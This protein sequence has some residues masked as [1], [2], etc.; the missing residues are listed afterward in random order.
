MCPRRHRAALFRCE[1]GGDTMA[2]D[3]SLRAERAW[4]KIQRKAVSVVFTKPGINLKTGSS[5]AVELAAQTVKISSDSR[6]SVIGGNAGVAPKRAVIV[7]GIV[8]HPTEPDSD[9]K[10]GYTFPYAGESY[11]VVDIIPG[12]PGE[13]QAQAT[14]LG[15]AAV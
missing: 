15:S 1:R 5:P 3:A 2:I 14:T 7:Y 12:T 13:I 6:A 9:I 10:I 8:G 11:R 4:L